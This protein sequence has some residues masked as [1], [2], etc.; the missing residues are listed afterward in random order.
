MA[1]GGKT[2]AQIVDDMADP[3]MAELDVSNN[4][5]V[6]IHSTEALK[7]IAEALKGHQGIKK[8]VLRE[9]E[10]VDAGCEVLS[11]V[12]RVNDVI[13][14][15]VLEKNKI[16][17]AGAILLADALTTNKGLRTLNLMQQATKNFGEET[18]EHFITMFHD[19][20]TL[21]KIMWR[22]ESRKSF[23]LNKLQTR[24]VEIK[25]RQDKGEDFT[26]FLPDHLKPGAAGAAPPEAA[27]APAAPEPAAEAALAQIAEEDEGS[28]CKPAI[29]PALHEQIEEQFDAIEA[30]VGELKVEE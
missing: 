1:F 10:I 3:S 29:K 27:P 2:I 8:V 19:N 15:L 25:K 23:M 7:T 20:V 11:E 5:S 26:S 28:P 18:L 9:C 21:T 4:A 30:A 14:E 24:N 6:K 17:S 13:E 16:T 22:L 12:L